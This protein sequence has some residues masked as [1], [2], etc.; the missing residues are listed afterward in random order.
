MNQAF[1]DEQS[2]QSHIKAKIVC[3]YFIRWARIMKNS[4]QGD[5][6][7]IDLFAGPG[8]YSDGTPSVPLL[9]VNEILKDSR[10][11]R[12]MRIVFNDADANNIR[13]LEAEILALPQARE[14]IKSV[15]FSANIIDS[16]FWESIEIDSGIPVLS[17][18]DPFGYKGLTM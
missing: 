7:Y 6:S 2:E 9:I 14:L 17:F 18:V 4:W 5:I 13:N 15:Q 12:R 8:K 3:D 1:F 10:L 16:G 11:A